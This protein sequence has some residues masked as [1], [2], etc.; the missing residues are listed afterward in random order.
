M[1][2]ILEERH[3]IAKFFDKDD[4]FIFYGLNDG[5]I[6]IVTPSGCNITLPDPNRGKITGF[7]LL[8]TKESLI[9]FSGSILC[10]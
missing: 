10:D 5:T 2:I 1:T 6:K 8:K 3:T 4:N 9:L 7:E